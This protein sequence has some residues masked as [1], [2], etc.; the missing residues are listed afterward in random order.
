[1]RIFLQAALPA[2]DGGLSLPTAELLCAS[3]HLAGARATLPYVQEH[4][5]AYCLDGVCLDSTSEL[6]YFHGLANALQSL[7]SQSADAAAKHPDLASL[8]S[9]SPQHASQHALAEGCYA[10]QRLQVL[11]LQTDERHRARVYSAGGLHAGA[12]LCVFPMTMHAT[13]RARDITSWRLLFGSV[14]SCQSS[15]PCTARALFVA[16]AL[17]TMRTHSIRGRAAVATATRSGRS[18]MMRYSSCLFMW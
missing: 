2:K 3:A 14:L 8:L 4:A 5:N 12:W 11:Q 17:N 18:D 7:H 1:M 15:C 13:A 6:P 16:V 10:K 9:A